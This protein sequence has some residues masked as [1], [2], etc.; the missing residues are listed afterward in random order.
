MVQNL[1][2]L[3]YGSYLAFGELPPY[4]DGKEATQERY[5]DLL[6]VSF[7]CVISLGLLACV[8]ENLWELCKAHNSGMFAQSAVHVRN[9]ASIILLGGLVGM[10]F[11]LILK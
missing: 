6:L 9:G 3:G 7:N 10:L 8:L 4:F 11:A 2:L 1:V 5:N